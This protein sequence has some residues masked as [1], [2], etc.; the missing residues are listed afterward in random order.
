MK[1]PC[2]GCIHYKFL[3]GTANG[4]QKNCHYLLDTGKSR[5]CPAGEGCI[6]KE[7]STKGVKHH[8]YP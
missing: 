6:H 4:G 8:V 2:D 3:C 5:G 7:L 1:H